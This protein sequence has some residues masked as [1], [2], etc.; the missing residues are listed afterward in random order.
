MPT[1][2]L[3]TDQAIESAMRLREAISAL[4]G[5]TRARPADGG[6]GLLL[7]SLQRH[8]GAMERL[9]AHAAPMSASLLE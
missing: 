6:D 4:E 9:I 1:K 5:A 3:T 7:R 8:L 2:P